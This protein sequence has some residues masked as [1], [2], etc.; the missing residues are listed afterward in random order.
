MSENKSNISN[1]SNV[2]IGLLTLALLGSV[3]TS[4]MKTQREL[5]DTQ[6]RLQVRDESIDKLRGFGGN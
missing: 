1:I 5:E 4:G 2:I 3:L 6:L